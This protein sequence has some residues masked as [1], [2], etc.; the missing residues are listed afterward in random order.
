MAKVAFKKPRRKI[1]VPSLFA[2]RE[3]MMAPVMAAPYGVV[4]KRTNVIRQVSMSGRAQRKTMALSAES[5][6]YIEE[7]SKKVARVSD[8]ELAKKP[9]LL[10]RRIDRIAKLSPATVAR[11]RLAQG[12]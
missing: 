12:A 11:V 10:A 8:S 5:I 1:N 6:G 9:W 4:D 3:T 7:R 2:V